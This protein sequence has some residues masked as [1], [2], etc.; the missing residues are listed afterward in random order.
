M[1]ASILCSR[2]GRR[3][4]HHGES[5]PKLDRKRRA[6]SFGPNESWARSL[7]CPPIQPAYHKR[8]HEEELFKLLPCSKYPQR[9][10]QLGHVI[11]SAKILS[12]MEIAKE[13][14]N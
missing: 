13:A 7:S 5:G 2:S 8:T 10:M 14:E 3:T 9:N 11:S 6:V 1:W 4:A 12:G